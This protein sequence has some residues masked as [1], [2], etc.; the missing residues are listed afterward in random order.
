MGLWTALPCPLH[1]SPSPAAPRADCSF[2]PLTWGCSGQ[3]EQDLTEEEAMSYAP[4]IVL[5]K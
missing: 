4:C 2:A 1:P 3:N 5:C